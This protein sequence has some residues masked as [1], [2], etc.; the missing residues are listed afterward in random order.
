MELGWPL[1][2]IRR[3]LCSRRSLIPPTVHWPLSVVMHFN[4]MK[5]YT[6]MRHMN[7][8]AEAVAES[9]AKTKTKDSELQSAAAALPTQNV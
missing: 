9:A 8:K 7:C 4:E 6:I 1:A 2:G 5:S 3:K